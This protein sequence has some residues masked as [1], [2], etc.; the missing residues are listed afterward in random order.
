MKMNQSNG[1]NRS[2]S[3]WRNGLVM[4][5]GAF[6]L[7]GTVVADEAPVAGASS[8][9]GKA[10]PRISPH[11]LAAQRRAQQLEE[12]SAR[13]GLQSQMHKDTVRRHLAPT[14]LGA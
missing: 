6:V 2:R 7:M 3:G 12:P 10:A 8:E 14:R 11:V 1:V 9:S 5:V 13:V 4:L